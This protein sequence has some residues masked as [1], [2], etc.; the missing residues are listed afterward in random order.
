M[1]PTNDQSSS[2]AVSHVIGILLVVATYWIVQHVYQADMLGGTSVQSSQWQLG[3]GL[4]GGGLVVLLIVLPFRRRMR[5]GAAKSFEPWMVFHSYPGVVAGIILLHHGFFHFSFDLRGILL[6]L[7]MI[8]ILLGVA[9]LILRKLQGEKTESGLMKKLSLY[10][11]L[12][13]VLTGA[14]LIVHILFDAVV[15]Q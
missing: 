12:F 14:L 9:C 15:R 1:E 4:A 8:A 2:S 6:S 13:S 7:L 11:R 10:H 3:L 5:Q